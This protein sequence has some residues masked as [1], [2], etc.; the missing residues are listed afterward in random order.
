[1]GR[2]CGVVWEGEQVLDSVELDR[3]A[4][5]VAEGQYEGYPAAADRLR[6]GAAGLV[7]GGAVP[8][9][10]EGPWTVREH[11]NRAGH[12]VGELDPEV[13]GP[14][15]EC[16]DAELTARWVADGFMVDQCG[17]PLHP[18]WL[19][20]LG[21]PRIGAPTGLG[22]FFRYGPNATVDPVIYRYRRGAGAVGAGDSGPVELLLIK[23]RRGGRWA[24]PGGFRDRGDL[25]AEATAR[26][27]A[28]E[29]TGLTD[30][31]GTG[32][33]VAH[34]RP[35][36]LITTLHAWT[37]NTVVL[38][39]ADQD[40]LHDVPPVAG[41]DAVDAV[42]FDAAGIAELE[43]FDVHAKYIN[44]MLERL[45]RGRGTGTGTGEGERRS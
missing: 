21:D 12:G 8:V 11:P 26:R 5:K 18:H 1:M 38:I 17:R 15:V 24:L 4:A 28:G 35:V 40:Y 39:H 37:E 19:Q 16:L 33:V 45:E 22:F 2:P 31:G 43:L 27:E 7:V 6:I 9:V 20:L 23:R 34:S 10:P 29:E 30:L 32:E 44:A 14:G 36:G 13:P 25:N 3:I 42:W 41:D